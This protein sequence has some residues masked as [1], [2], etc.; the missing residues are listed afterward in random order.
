MG[1]GSRLVGFQ[2]KNRCRRRIETV[3]DIPCG[4]NRRLNVGNVRFFPALFPPRNRISLRP[5]SVETSVSSSHRLGSTTSSS[6][7]SQVRSYPKLVC[8]LFICMPT[9]FLQRIATGSIVFHNTIHCTTPHND[10]P[11]RVRSTTAP[12]ATRIGLNLDTGNNR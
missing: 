11:Y 9:V 3:H 7:S 6:S 12:Y 8:R 10:L 1:N 5:S 4:G 2:L